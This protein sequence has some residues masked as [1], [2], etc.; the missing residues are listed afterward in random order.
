M[1]RLSAFVLGAVPFW[2]S[3][4]SHAEGCLRA[5]LLSATPPDKA[6]SVPTNALPS[7]RYRSTAKYDDEVVRF[8]REGR[9]LIEIVPTFEPATA[10]LSFV[11]PGLEPYASYVIEWPGLGGVGATSRGKPITVH[12]GTGAGEDHTAPFFAGAKSVDW[13]PKRELDPCTDRHEDRF[14]FSLELGD[15]AEDTGNG[16]LELLVFQTKGPNMQA[17]EGPRQVHVQRYSSGT[18]TFTRPFGDAEGDVCFA[19]LVRDTA[20][21]ISASANVQ[22]CTTT[23]LPPV[24]EG[25]SLSARGGAGG[26]GL[27]AAGLAAGGC[28]LVRGRRRFSPPRG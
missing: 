27:L 8:G 11:P 22:V 7:A 4:V 18:A 9:A 13:T 19:A 2:L 20:G 28:L 15:V 1:R 21:Q 17:D 5:D 14:E 12:F 6:L 25:C 16:L 3:A 10:T 23:K 24:F 26:A